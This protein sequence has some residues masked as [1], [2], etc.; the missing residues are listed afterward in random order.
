MQTESLSDWTEGLQAVFMRDP[1]SSARPIPLDLVNQIRNQ[2]RR[3][4]AAIVANIAAGITQNESITR[5]DHQIEKLVA[6]VQAA[7]AIAASRLRRDQ[8]KFKR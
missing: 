8:I 2:D 6:F 1:G 4:D 7:L 5:G 3:R